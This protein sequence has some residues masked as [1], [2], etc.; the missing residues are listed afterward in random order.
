MTILI[1]S[2]QICGQLSERLEK[3][4]TLAQASV[5][6]YKVSKTFILS[7]LILHS[8]V[9]D[10]D[11]PS[12]RDHFSKIF[13]QFVFRT[14]WSRAILALWRWKR[15]RP[16]LPTMRPFQTNE[17]KRPAKS[18]TNARLTRKMK[19]SSRLEGCEMVILYL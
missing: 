1:V 19:C 2:L 14:K 9:D 12:V 11:C 8:Q 7:L 5:K 18:T 16:P 10:F 17:H 6:K 3:Q 4:Q 13:N 15:S